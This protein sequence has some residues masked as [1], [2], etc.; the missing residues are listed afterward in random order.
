MVPAIDH[1]L[2]EKTRQPQADEAAKHQNSDRTSRT[3]QIVREIRQPKNQDEE[4]KIETSPNLLM[5]LLSKS[6]PRAS[7]NSD[8]M[9]ARASVAGGESTP[10]TW[11]KQSNIAETVET[12]MS[13][14]TRNPF[15]PVRVAESDVHLVTIMHL[16]LCEGRLGLRRASAPKC[17]L[18]FR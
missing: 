7:R 16:S 17:G 15:P 10:R 5:I 18:S 9:L 3:P 11:K 4:T 8:K 13:N 2:D 12:P 1:Q 6:I 14:A